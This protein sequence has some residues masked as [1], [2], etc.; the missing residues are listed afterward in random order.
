MPKC[1]RL[2]RAALYTPDESV[3]FP[4]GQFPRFHFLYVIWYQIWELSRWYLMICLFLSLSNVILNFIYVILCILSIMEISK[5]SVQYQKRDTLNLHI[6]LSRSV[7]RGINWNNENNI[8]C[9]LNVYSFRIICSS[10]AIQQLHTKTKTDRSGRDRSEKSTT[11]WKQKAKTESNWEACRYY[12]CR[13]KQ[14]IN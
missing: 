7:F 6:A 3:R 2:L 10:I 1:L 9:L 4:R 5:N 8:S 11:S 14:L 12:V 13:N